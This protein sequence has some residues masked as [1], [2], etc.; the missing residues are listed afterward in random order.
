M[1]PNFSKPFKIALGFS[2]ILALSLFLASYLHTRE[3]VF[4]LLNANLGQIGD[5]VFN[6]I[7]YLA[8]GWIWIPYF[9]LVFG[10]FKKDALFILI[11]FLLSTI[12]TQ[13]PKNFIWEKVSRP[14]ASGI[15]HDQIHTV[16]GV[17]MHL[18]NSFPSGHSATAFT[19]FLVTVYLYPKKEVLIIGAL[20]ATACGYSRVYLGQHFPL[21][22]AGGIT[23]AL[24][25]ILL[26]IY[27]RKNEKE[28]LSIN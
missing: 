8:E 11:N 28:N 20:Y 22:V 25:T 7:S 23:V 26:S 13:L 15:P 24:I 2:L 1:H 10:W 5:F 19:L 17:E 3:S 4:L 9:M 14:M 21:D 27:I 18:W 12:L 16:K 6:L